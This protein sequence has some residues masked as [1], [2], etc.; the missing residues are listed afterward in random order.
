MIEDPYDGVTG[1]NSVPANALPR[2]V[3]LKK[4][5]DAPARS[6]DI[7]SWASLYI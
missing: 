2:T 6:S 4:L 5:Y 7:T 1:T 3:S